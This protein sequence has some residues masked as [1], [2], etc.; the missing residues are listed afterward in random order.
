MNET[1]FLRLNLNFQIDSDS[2]LPPLPGCIRDI[3]LWNNPLSPG[4]T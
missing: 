3:E 1:T 2:N 4:V